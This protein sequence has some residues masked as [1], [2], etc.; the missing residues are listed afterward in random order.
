MACP[1][2]ARKGAQVFD[3]SGA[4]RIQV[5]IPDEFQEIDFLIDHDGLVAIL[6]EVACPIVAA[7]ELA[8][9]AGQERSHAAAQGARLSSHQQMGVVRQDREGVYGEVSRVRESGNSPD[10]ILPIPVIPK[11][12]LAVQT[13]D[14]HMVQS[15]GCVESRSAWHGNESLR[16]SNYCY[17]V[18]LDLIVSSMRVDSHSLIP[19]Y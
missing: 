12:D 15:A 19:F 18:V 2:V 8:G 9:V 17:N 1:G 3:D 10:K 4:K 16:Y 14:H 11:D 13:P 7:V 5:E 6:E